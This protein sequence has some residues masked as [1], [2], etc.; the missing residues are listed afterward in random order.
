LRGE[1]KHLLFVTLLLF[2]VCAGPARSSEP[3]PELRL[4][5]TPAEA[6]VG[7]RL[8]AKLTLVLPP[9]AGFDGDPLGPQLGPFAVESESWSGPD[10][11]G[12]DRASGQRWSW[13]GT[14]ISFRTG[15]VE[16]PQVRVSFESPDGKR[17]SVESAAVPVA[18]RSV[19]E[20][21]PVTAGEPAEIADIK[22]PASLRPDYSSL[23]AAAGA[24]VLLLLG[25]VLLWWLQRRYAAKLARV[26]MPE[27]PFLRTPPHVWVYAE[28]QKLL[29]RRLAEQG[30]FGLFYME[31]SRILKRYLSGRYRIEL[32]EHTTAELPGMLRQS[33][34]P[35]GAIAEVLEL[36]DLADR[37]K[38]AADA[39]DETGC[40]RSIEAAYEIVDATKSLE[41]AEPS[42]QQGAA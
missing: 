2:G 18:I 12:E 17:D 38:F 42:R 8:Q 36:L 5:V 40:R 14:L 41:E 4:E 1:S 20:T 3:A 39:P 6:T 24:L 16:V 29:E 9:G 30:E 34:A 27:D 19:L 7:D 28:L 10:P 23:W 26:K 11:L 37:V 22:E 32:M 33:R 35:E 13:T 21:E 31:L 25:A 15:D